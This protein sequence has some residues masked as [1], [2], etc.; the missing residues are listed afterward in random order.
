MSLGKSL[1]LLNEAVNIWQSARS[2]I[3]LAAEGWVL[4]NVKTCTYF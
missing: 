1:V 3:I 4:E 2:R